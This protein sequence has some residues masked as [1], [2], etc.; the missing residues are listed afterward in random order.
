MLCAGDYVNYGL[1]RDSYRYS[2]SSCLFFCVFLPSFF[3]GM[4]IALS[5]RAIYSS[6]S[7]VY[8]VTLIHKLIIS[9]I[10]LLFLISRFVFFI[11]LVCCA[12]LF[13]SSCFCGFNLFM[14]IKGVCIYASFSE[15]ILLF[16]IC[17]AFLFFISRSLS[18]PAK[19]YNSIRMYMSENII[20]LVFDLIV[21]FLSVTYI[22]Y[23][24]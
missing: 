8:N 14:I 20:H 3:V 18:Y 6:Y 5:C 17:F 23:C 4:Y 19:G 10:S 22:Y 7:F 1:K 24:L 21:F 15:V 9:F 12:M 16:V 11:R 2:I 13:A